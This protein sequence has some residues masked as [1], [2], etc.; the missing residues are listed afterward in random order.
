MRIAYCICSSW[1]LDRRPT[2]IPRRGDTA[3]RAPHDFED[4][5]AGRKFILGGLQLLIGDLIAGKAGS[6]HERRARRARG[7]RTGCGIGSVRSVGRWVGG[8]VGRWVGGSVGRWVGGSVRSG[9]ASRCSSVSRAGRRFRRRARAR[10]LWVVP[11]RPCRRPPAPTD[12]AP[13]GLRTTGPGAALGDR[14]QARWPEDLHD[15]L[16]RRLRALQAALTRLAE[17]QSTAAGS[18]VAP[19]TYAIAGPDAGESLGPQ[20]MCMDAPSGAGSTASSRR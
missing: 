3:D 20:C 19:G 4:T 16:E 14:R 6:T 10:L 8:S 11:V 17:R 13:G 18:T 5:R 7:G 2:L 9:R 1:H 12:P 15:V